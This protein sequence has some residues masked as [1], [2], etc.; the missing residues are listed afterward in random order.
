MILFQTDGFPVLY[1]SCIQNVWKLAE[2]CPE[3]MASMAK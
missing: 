1:V 3:A 2:G